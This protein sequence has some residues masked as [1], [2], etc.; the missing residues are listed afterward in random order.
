MKHTNT[1]TLSGKAKHI[2][3]ITFG[4]NYKVIV[5]MQYGISVGVSIEGRDYYN[6]VMSKLKDEPTVLMVG[7][8]RSAQ[9]KNKPDKWYY[10]ISSSS[11]SV[12]IGPELNMATVIGTVVCSE[13]IGTEVGP[14]SRILISCTSYSKTREKKQTF[15]WA[16]IDNAQPLTN[17][18]TILVCGSVQRTGYITHIGGG[19][20]WLL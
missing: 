7:K 12:V 18:Q 8:F 15:V 1:V 14:K 20:I 9:D 4:N 3:T 16:V 13:Q 6:S 10:E 11:I 19:S 2:K 17:G 5:G